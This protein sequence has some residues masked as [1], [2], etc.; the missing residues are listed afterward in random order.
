MRQDDGSLRCDMRRECKDAVT[1]I[2]NKGYAYCRAHGVQ[3][4]SYRPCRILAPKELEQLK[5]GIPLAA[6]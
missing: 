1:H 6:Y 5:A 3:R 4:K 2:D